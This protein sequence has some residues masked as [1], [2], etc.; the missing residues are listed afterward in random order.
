MTRSVTPSLHSRQKD[1]TARQMR[2]F[3]VANFRSDVHP[4]ASEWNVKECV[5]P[6]EEERDGEIT[7]FD[8]VG[9]LISTKSRQEVKKS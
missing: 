4:V 8:V 3:L 9:A 1:Y 7:L 5:H 2:S 6:P